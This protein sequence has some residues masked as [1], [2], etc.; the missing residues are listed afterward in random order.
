LA[1]SCLLVSPEEGPFFIL[2][3]NVF[4]LFCKKDIETFRRNSGYPHILADYLEARFEELKRCL[5]DHLDSEEEEFNLKQ[6]GHMVVLSPTVD[7][8]YELKSVGLTEIG[9]LFTAIPEVIE[10]IVLTEDY[11]VY[12]ISI[13]YNN[14]FMMLF[15]VP[16]KE[17]LKHCKEAKP[18]L[19]RFGVSEIFFQ[20]K[21]VKQ[22]PSKKSRR[23]FNGKR[24]ITQGVDIHIPNFVCEVIWD[25]IESRKKS[26]S[27]PLD[28]LQIF[29]LYPRTKEGKHVQVIE[30]KQEQPKFEVKLVIPA[31]YFVTEKLYLI[32]SESYQTLML[33]REY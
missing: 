1:H 26:G 6:F 5:E 17:F 10:E 25:F 24:Y 22:K 8:L 21:G 2:G 31:N 7:N 12:Q 15:Y 20:P 33:A 18:Y 3:G 9:G 30:C 11:S 14:S 19:E 28:Y 13:I 32:D 23:L 27:P 16:K 4:E 29:E